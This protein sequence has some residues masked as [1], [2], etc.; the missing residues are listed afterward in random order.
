MQ[1]AVELL[2]LG[3]ARLGFVCILGIT[4]SSYNF[5]KLGQINQLNLYKISSQTAYDEHYKMKLLSRRN[6]SQ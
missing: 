3:R 2:S 4:L 1:E 5:M 6:R